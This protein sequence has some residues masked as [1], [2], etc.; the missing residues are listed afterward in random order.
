MNGV[1]RRA[2]DF[3]GK[4]G[5]FI[6]VVVFAGQPIKQE[7]IPNGLSSLYETGREKR[8]E[9]GLIEVTAI[10]EKLPLEIFL[11]RE[12]DRAF[13]KDVLSNLPKLADDPGTNW[14]ATLTDDQKKRFQ[15][16]CTDE[17]PSAGIFHQF[18]AQDGD[19]I[20]ALKILSAMFAL[21]REEQKPFR[22]GKSLRLKALGRTLSVSWN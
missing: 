1:L 18:D 8:M 10:L 16:V 13:C 6:N 4:I 21:D 2:Q 12:D 11:K 20:A 15:N 9:A 7:Q 5:S 14:C 17:G 19:L 22:G 3:F